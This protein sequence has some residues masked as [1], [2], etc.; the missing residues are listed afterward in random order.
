VAKVEA[1][2]REGQ[3][4]ALAEIEPHMLTLCGLLRRAGET[5]A[6]KFGND[7]AAVLNEAVERWN[8]GVHR[9]FESQKPLP[10]T[11]KEFWR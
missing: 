9:Y 4:V 1:D 7:A 2:E 10:R 8:E 6:R 5:L 11:A 3:S